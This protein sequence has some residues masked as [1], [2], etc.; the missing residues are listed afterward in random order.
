M[1]GWDLVLCAAMAYFEWRTYRHLA[2][3]ENDPTT[4]VWQQF[5][6][7]PAATCAVS[8]VIVSYNVAG[9]LAAAIGSVL[10][11]LERAGITGEIIVVDNASADDSVA[12]V[13]ECSPHVRLIAN[14]TNVGFGRAANQGMH[15]ALGE[16]VV[17][18]NPDAS[19]RPGFFAAIEGYLA[20]EPHVGLLGPQIVGTDE[21]SQPS[22]RRAYTIA[23]AIL[24]STPLQWWFGET[25]ALHRFY[26]RDLDLAQVARVDWVE[27]A[28][29]IVRREVLKA[30]GGF[31]PRFFM[32]FEETD[33]CGRIRAA[34][35]DVAYFPGAQVLHHRSQS[36]VQDLSARALNFH[37][38]RHAFLVKERGRPVA[39]MLRFV[40]GLLFAVHTVLQAA[41]LLIRRNQELRQNV[42]VL[43]RVTLWYLSGI[44]GRGQHPV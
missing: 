32:Y 3:L 15:A 17:V 43:G 8:V 18:L 1:V 24:E 40:I 16:S 6:A 22:C 7:I 21:T 44:S 4:I 10:E 5:R 14:S 36:A 19:V 9:L 28:C 37:Q 33:W 12:K 27:G 42:A 23:T 13:K 41:K 30:V 35:W 34:G 26:C 39:L 31:D 29:L 38:S 20:Q 2:A 11:D 25:P